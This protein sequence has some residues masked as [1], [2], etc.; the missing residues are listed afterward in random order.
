MSPKIIHNQ[1]LSQCP[2][3]QRLRH[4]CRDRFE[5]PLGGRKAQSLALSFRSVRQ[6]SLTEKTK[7]VPL[8]ITNPQFMGKLRQGV[9]AVAAGLALAGCSETNAEDN[10]QAEIQKVAAVVETTKVTRGQCIALATKA[11]KIECMKTL[12]AQRVAEITA[13]DTGLEKDSETITQNEKDNE[14]RRT[15]VEGLTNEVE[16]LKKVVALQEQPTQ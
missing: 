2:Q 14:Q 3:K 8:K 12:K 6:P 16:G 11:E 4:L 5:L 7:L 9:M 10:T 13:L 1:K 15:T